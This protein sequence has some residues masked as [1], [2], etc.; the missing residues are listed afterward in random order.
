MRESTELRPHRRQH[1]LVNRSFQFRFVRA[2]VLVLFVMAAAAVLGIY[3]AIWFT[4]YSFELVNDR[5]LV[6]LF[7]TVS[8]TVVLELILLVPV[9]TWLGI[10]VTHKVAGPLVRIRAALFQ[11]TQGNFDIHLTLR[12]GDALTDLAEDINRLATFL[13]SRSR[14]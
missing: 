4:L 3:A 8:W 7:N 6:A 1:W 12:K 14:S 2:M 5:Y 10:L 9:V 11:M 13:R